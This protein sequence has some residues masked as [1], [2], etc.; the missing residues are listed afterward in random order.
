MRN[1]KR[2]REGDYYEDE[3]YKASRKELSAEQVNAIISLTTEQAR[4]FMSIIIHYIHEESLSEIETLDYNYIRFMLTSNPEE[5]MRA[6]SL[7]AENIEVIIEE[8]LDETV[9]GAQVIATGDGLNEMSSV[10]LYGLQQQPCEYDGLSSVA[11]MISGIG[12]NK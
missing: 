4:I 11:G 8:N 9:G 1:I 12:V 2:D 10:A 6:I 5:L 7:T 3:S